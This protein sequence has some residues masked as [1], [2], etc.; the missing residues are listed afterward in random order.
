MESDSERIKEIFSSALLKKQP[1][2]RERY[3]TEA[4]QDSPHLRPQVESLLRAHEQ[5]GEF[6]GQAGKLAPA[7]G[8][9]RAGALVGRYKLLELVGEGGFGTVWM[10]EQ[11]EPVRRRVALK[12]I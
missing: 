5:A 7:L 2:E 8:T 6:L 4:C 11:Q 1:S 12:I 9:E 3:L 10:A